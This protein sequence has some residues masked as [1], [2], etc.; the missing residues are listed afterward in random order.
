GEG[1]A[2]R[3]G[4][5]DDPSRHAVPRPD[6]LLVPRARTLSARGGA[7]RLARAADPRGGL[8]GR[9]VALGRGGADGPRAGCGWPRGAHVAGDAGG[10]VARARP[11][12]PGV[13]SARARP[14]LLRAARRRCDRAPRRRRD[15][16]VGTVAGIEVRGLGDA[17]APGLVNSSPAPRP[18]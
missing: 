18:L 10:V 16:D 3:G 8:R 5:V 2:G 17:V 7:A 1:G 6:G 9:G 12:A 14:S 4:A 15:A 11:A 13:P